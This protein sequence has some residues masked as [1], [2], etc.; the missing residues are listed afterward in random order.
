MANKTLFQTLRGKLVPQTNAVNEASGVAYGFSAKHPLAQY[1]V[2]G[3][4]NSTYYASAE[5]QL[6]KVL[7]LR[8]EVEPA[9]IART[10]VY[11]RQKAVAVE[12]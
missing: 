7:K 2:T 11:C 4:L 10:A 9:F 5:A 12:Q 3:C 6:Q 8:A 1:A